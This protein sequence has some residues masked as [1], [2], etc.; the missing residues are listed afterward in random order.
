M[1][2]LITTFAILLLATPALAEAPWQA[3]EDTITVQLSAED[4]VTATTGKVTLNVSAALKDSDAANTRKEI[5]SGAQKIAKTE[6]RMVNF[7]RSTDQSGLE[8]WDATLEARLPEA[9]LTGVSNAAK[10]ASRPGLQFN[11]G[12][13]DLSP[14]LDEME[15]GRAKLRETLMTK[16]NQELARVNKNANGR[17][18][19]VGDI[20]YGMM[21]MPMPMVARAKFGRPEMMAM[22]AVASAP[23][24]GG[25]D[26][27]SVDQKLEM[28]ATVTYAASVK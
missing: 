19:R 22:D 23:A 13:V 17:T 6:W 2:K 20:Q 14:T 24:S 9:Q 21:G 8:R 3:P 12:N 1:K 25:S 15:A 27:F 28:T 26:S 7:N 5:L 11:V 4:Y 18:Y 10:S 16:A